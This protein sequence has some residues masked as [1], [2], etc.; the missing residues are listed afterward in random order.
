MK[1]FRIFHGEL[2][3]RTKDGKVTGIEGHAAVFNKLSVDLGGFRERVMPRAFADDLKSGPDV[4]ALFNHDPNII[5][6]RTKAK[7]LRLKEDSQGLHFDCDVPD[8]QAARDVMTSIA[9]GDIDQCSF[10]FTVTNQKWSDEQDPD[11]S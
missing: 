5:L 8:T 10:G 3:A 9:R 6:G 4:R 11:S 1:E 2:R 7:T